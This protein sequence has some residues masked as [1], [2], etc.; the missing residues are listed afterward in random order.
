MPPF[1]RSRISSFFTRNEI[2]GIDRQR[3]NSRRTVEVHESPGKA[4]LSEVQILR[5]E[6]SSRCHVGQGRDLRMSDSEAN[7]FL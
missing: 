6:F 2:G 4:G 3:W 7:C 1:G 5:S